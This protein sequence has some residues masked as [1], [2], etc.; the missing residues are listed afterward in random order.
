MALNPED[1]CGG[2]HHAKVVTFINEKIAG[3]VKGPEFYLEN[4]SLSWEEVGDKL[5]A[6]LE[7]SDVP[8]EAKEACTWGGLALGV[9]FVRRQSQLQGHRVQQLYNFAKLHRSAAQALAAD[10]EE[11][12]AQQEPERKEAA[13][14]LQLLEASLAKVQKERDW[15]RWKLLQDVRAA[16]SSAPPL[17]RPHKPLPF[18]HLTPPSTTT[19]WPLPLAPEQVSTLPPS[20]QELQQPLE[21]ATGWPSLA[22][23]GGAGTEGEGEEEEEAEA[24]WWPSVAT[25]RGAGTEREGEEEQEAVATWWPSLVAADVAGAEGEEEERDAAGAATAPVIE[26]AQEL[27]GSFLQLFGAVGRKILTSRGQREGELRGRKDQEPHQQRRPPVVHR[28][29]DWDYPWCKAVNFS[30][31]EICFCCGKGIWVQNLVNAEM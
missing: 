5:R 13:L 4:M 15:L 1:P 17:P 28:L 9:G 20:P 18:R 19:L 22:T 25:A 11:L 10:L 23:A 29:G 27:G 30:R 3:H 2:F 12:N 24:T 16:P 31:R 7:D 21:Q 8:S 6:I 14:Q 26:A